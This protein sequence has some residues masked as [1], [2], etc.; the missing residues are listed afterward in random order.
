MKKKQFVDYNQIKLSITNER[1]PDNHRLY[2]SRYTKGLNSNKSHKL[3]GVSK[4]FGLQKHIRET[5]ILYFKLRSLVF[6][7]GN[8]LNLIISSLTPL[9]K[10]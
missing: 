3:Q 2:Q 5:C 4:N 7:N 9:R 1:D 10:I 6:T 8:N